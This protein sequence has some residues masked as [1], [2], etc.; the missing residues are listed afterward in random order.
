[1]KGVIILFA[2]ISFIAC[3]QAPKVS[4]W[5]G[6]DRTGVYS[7]TN[8]LTSWPI[9]GPAVVWETDSIGNGYS[10]PVMTDEFVFVTGE[11]DSL[12]YLYK[13]DKSGKKIWRVNYSGEWTQNFVGTRGTPTFCDEMI[14][15]CSGLGDV[16]CMDANS[17][18]KVWHRNML[19]DFEGVSPRFGFSQ[20]LVVDDDKVFCM[21]GG[22]TNN[23]VAL[24]RFTG[25]MVW[26]AKGFGEHPGYNSP[27]VIERGGKKILATFSAYHLL[28]FDMNTGDLLW[29]HEQTNT[30]PEERKPGIGDTHANTVLYE[31]GFIYYAAGDGNCGVKLKLAED[32]NSIEQVWQT[33]VFDNYM[34]GIVKV[35]GR[36]YGSSHAR[37]QLMALDAETGSKVDSLKLGRGITIFADNHFYFYNEQGKVFLV[38]LTPH[39]MQEVSSFKLEKGTHEHFAH[40]VISD[41]VLYLRHGNYLGAYQIGI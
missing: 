12:G 31:D 17:G 36:L 19:I 24:N 29:S 13:Y 39:G 6:A 9:D 32:G 23:V 21:P 37:R 20:G 1:M 8:L 11:T 30:K 3:K 41:G 10:S 33:K 26:S 5:R 25:D 16:V 4:E 28:G 14:Y 2:L 38:G 7:D 35:D 27:K 22:K 18:E 40:P 15:I 34:S